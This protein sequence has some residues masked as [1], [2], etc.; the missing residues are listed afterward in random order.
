MRESDAESSSQIRK[1]SRLAVSS[2][3]LGILTILLFGL[4]WLPCLICGHMACNRIKKRN[5]TGKKL[6]IAGLIMGYLGIV[7]FATTV[8]VSGLRKVYKPYTLPSGKVIKFM[9]VQKWKE[10]GGEDSL[11]LLYQTDTALDSKEELR[12]EAGHIWKFFQVNVER[13]GMKK[14]RIL[15]HGPTK[16]RFMRRRKVY[17][18]LIIRQED[19]SWKFSEHKDNEM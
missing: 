14:A 7:L 17:G 19:G 15:A 6:A 16:G 18:F 2:F 10:I 11:V 1:M 4:T 8:Y 3:I 13:E 5:L 9:G 12:E